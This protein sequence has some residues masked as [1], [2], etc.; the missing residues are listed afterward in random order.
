LMNR[1]RL[2]ED[3]SAAMRD[4]AEHPGDAAQRRL[5]GLCMARNA[6]RQ[7]DEGGGVEA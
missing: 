1:N 7:G 2:E 3:V 5:I 6:L 4:L